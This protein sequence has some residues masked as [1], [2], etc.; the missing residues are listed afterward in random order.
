VGAG[1]LL[2]EGK[3]FGE[4]RVI[5]GL[6]AKAVREVSQEQKRFMEE[7]AKSYARLAA[8]YRG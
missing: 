7:K 2:T 6:P 8:E 5:I 1:A 3:N 4:G